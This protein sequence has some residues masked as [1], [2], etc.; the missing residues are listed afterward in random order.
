MLYQFI[1][2]LFYNS[3]LS[4]PVK[5][6]I[7]T[8]WLDH[9]QKELLPV[10][11]DGV[12]LDVL[13]DRIKGCGR[14]RSRR[15]LDA[16]MRLML[17]HRVAEGH[18]QQNRKAARRYRESYRTRKRLGSTAACCPLIIKQTLID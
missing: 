17:H 9:V 8:S 1:R 14:S 6:K 16:M 3:S 13:A 2:L 10:G 15:G 11:T 18:P 7:L 4:V 12:Q 5:A